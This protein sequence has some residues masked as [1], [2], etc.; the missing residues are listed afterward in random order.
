MS[1][2]Q[3]PL[4]S[5]S[6]ILSTGVAGIGTSSQGR[7]HLPRSEAGK[8]HAR[9]VPD[10]PQQ[11]WPFS[12]TTWKIFNTIVLFSFLGRVMWSWQT[13]DV[14]KKVLATRWTISMRLNPF[15]LLILHLSLLSWT[16]H[17]VE[18]W[19]IWHLKY[20]TDPGRFNLTTRS[21]ILVLF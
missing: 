3:S 2:S 8:Y 4:F 13:L 6:Y 14:W 5:S 17:S 11:K 1:C 21:R 9:Q 16:I 10:Y 19:S 12:T 15:F 20:S 7:D 18:P